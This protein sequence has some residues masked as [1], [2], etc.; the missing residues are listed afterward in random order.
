MIFRRKDWNYLILD[1]AHQIKNFK[2][3]KWQTLLNF[4]SEHRLLLTG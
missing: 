1:E 4:K 2:T 3:K